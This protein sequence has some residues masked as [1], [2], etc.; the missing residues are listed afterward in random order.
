MGDLSD[1]LCLIL[2]GYILL[3]QKM[4]DRYAYSWQYRKPEYGGKSMFT[5]WR[6]IWDFKDEKY[7]KDK[8]ILSF[9]IPFTDKKRK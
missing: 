9:Y 5:V 4:A 1:M 6:L 2:L 7:Y 3:R 8:C